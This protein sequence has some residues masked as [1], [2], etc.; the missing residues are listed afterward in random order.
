MMKYEDSCLIS[1]K[2]SLDTCIS[3]EQCSVLGESTM[4]PEQEEITQEE[5]GEVMGSDPPTIWMKSYANG[6]PKGSIL[7]NSKQNK[8]RWAYQAKGYLGPI[9]RTKYCVSVLED[10]NYV[11]HEVFPEIIFGPKLKILKGISDLSIA[12]SKKPF[13]HN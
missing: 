6:R 10:G 12:R 5:N 4:K 9:L 13:T 11:T 7:P 2:K 3:S 1:M 8:Q